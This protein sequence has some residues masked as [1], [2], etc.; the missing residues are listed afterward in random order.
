MPQLSTGLVIGGAY[1]NKLRRVLFAQLRGELKEGKIDSKQIAFRAGELNR[2]L[3]EIL[4]NKLKIDKGDAVRIRIEYDVEDRDIKWKYD[5]FSIEVF[6][7]VPDEEIEPIIKDTVEQIETILARPV[8]EE[9]RV[10]TERE[11][12]EVERELARERLLP[13]PI[14]AD[15]AVVHGRTKTGELLAILKSRDKGNIGL[16][17]A[18]EHEKGSKV[19]V[20]LVPTEQEAYIGEKIV[21]E[22]LDQL[23]SSEELILKQVNSRI[24][25]KID[26]DE[27]EKIIRSK[28]EALF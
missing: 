26:K 22:P 23:E 7:R 6:R 18:E 27:A 8:T 20:I 15:T 4:V 11:E 16:F 10:W 2:I 19:T 21:E 1:A 3:F 24:Y 28:L 13:P 25:K 5:T 14:E 17:S 12:A 9:E